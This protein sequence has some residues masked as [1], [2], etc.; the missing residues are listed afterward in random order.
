MKIKLEI[1]FDSD[2]ELDV[3][4][5]HS[6]NEI[7]ACPPENLNR[8]NDGRIQVAVYTNDDPVKAQEALNNMTTLPDVAPILNPDEYGAPLPPAPAMPQPAP[9]TPPPAYVAPTGQVTSATSVQ[10]APV[11]PPTPP[12][13]DF[14]QAVAQAVTQ[15]PP[16]PPPAA[17]AAPE[18]ASKTTG[19]R[20]R[21][22]L[23]DSAAL[24][25]LT[26]DQ[27]KLYALQ[28]AGVQSFKEMTPELAQRAIAALEQLIAANAGAVPPQ[29]VEPTRPAPIQPPA[30]TQIAASDLLV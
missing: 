26:P 5:L 2:N 14:K 9:P 15:A 6:I 10:A 21:Q 7:I 20:I 11:A 22:L 3:A 17:A 19:L 1:L 8:G 12:A 30:P 28:A 29:P 24:P 4:K 25:G 27:V 23:A 18:D 16:T 13:P